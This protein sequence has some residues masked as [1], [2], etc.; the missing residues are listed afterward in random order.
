[1]SNAVFIY[2]TVEVSS[3]VARWIGRFSSR[4]IFPCTRDIARFHNE[5]QCYRDLGL[6]DVKC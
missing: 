6:V 2:L 4:L 1:M 3:G 5:T